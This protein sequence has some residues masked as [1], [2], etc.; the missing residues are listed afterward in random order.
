M[1]GASCDRAR[2]PRPVR[3][4]DGLKGTT[5][6]PLRPAGQRVL[7]FRPLAE[8]GAVVAGGAAM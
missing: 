1:D 2:L 4:R 8:G 3:G 5:V 6:Q 7:P